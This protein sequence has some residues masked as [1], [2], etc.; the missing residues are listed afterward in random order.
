MPR[1]RSLPVD[2]TVD[3]RSKLEFWLG[4]L[5]GAVNIPVDELP[6]GLASLAGVSP[7]SRILV[8]CAGGVRS[9]Q[10]AAILARAGYER[11][12]D[13]GGIAD[14]RAHFEAA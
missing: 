3:V 12:T 14:A 8:Y 9:A 4:H 10:A 7:K 13:G 11:V 6:H 2:L 5:P 1:F